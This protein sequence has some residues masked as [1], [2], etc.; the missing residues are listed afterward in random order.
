MPSRGLLILL[1]SWARYAPAAL[2]QLCRA[3]AAADQGRGSSAFL[4][5][6]HFPA[7]DSSGGISTPLW[8]NQIH[9]WPCCKRTGRLSARL[10]KSP[11]QNAPSN[12]TRVASQRHP[13]DLHLPTLSAVLPLP[14]FVSAS[15]AAQGPPVLRSHTDF[16]GC[17]WSAQL[18]NTDPPWRRNFRSA[19]FPRW[20]DSWDPLPAKRPFTRS[21]LL[22]DS[23]SA[24]GLSPP[25]S[26]SVCEDAVTSQE[27]R[28]W[29]REEPVR[30]SASPFFSLFPT[31]G[32][33]G[34][35]TTGT[36]SP[37]VRTPQS[38]K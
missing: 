18:S 2:P 12:L 9:D 16:V 10:Q 38:A 8:H 34:Y 33:S 29:R 22:L 17:C 30:Q 28:P 7:T 36:S 6:L 21:R 31:T 13:C 26:W 19:P 32:L 37:R 20:D 15:S 14:S 25:C 5:R 35:L 23:H 27:L 3:E 11:P 24:P 4:P 1:P